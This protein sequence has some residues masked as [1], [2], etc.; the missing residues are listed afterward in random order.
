MPVTPTI[1][2]LLRQDFEYWCIARPCLQKAKNTKQ[3][4]FPGHK[5]FAL[6]RDP[7]RGPTPSWILA[8]GLEL[9]QNLTLVEQ[10]TPVVPCVVGVTVPS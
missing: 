5:S 9:Q 8:S 3:L 6:W 1:L 10:A 4:V 2:R 7:G